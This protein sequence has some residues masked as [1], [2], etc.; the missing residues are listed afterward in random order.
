MKILFLSRWFPYPTTNGSKL[1]IYNLLRG[2]AKH[3]DVTLVSFAD[4]P[5]INPDV[6]EIRS[7]CSNVSVVPW[8]EFDPGSARARLGF[9]SFTPRSIIDTFSP[10]M[11]QTITKLLADHK[12]DLVIA[13]Q[14]SMASYRP[15]FRNV[16]A[17]FEEVEIGLSQDGTRDAYP[18]KW[19]RHAIT[20]LKLRTYLS[21]LLN[22]FQ[23]CTVASVSE[24][25]LLASNFSLH[26]VTLEVVPNCVDMSA[27][28]IIR[29]G[30]VPNQLIFSG[31][32]RYLPNY[33][34]VLWYIENVHPYVLEAV[35]DANLVIT[36]DHAN[37]PLPTV[38]NVRLAGFVDDIKSLISASSASVVPLWSGGGT[39]LKILEAMA[40]GTPVIA[41][42]KG[43]EGLRAQNEKHIL[44]ADE[45][46][47]FAECVVR[48]LRD[49]ELG[50]Q[51][52]SNARQF[53]RENYDWSITMPIFLSLAEKA[54]S[55]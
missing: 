43:A 18:L 51:V 41:T 49:K 31:S 45:P 23:A 16:P 2:L 37:L 24:K 47:K 55:G 1:R 17:I 8:R 39:R 12:Y 48:I 44:I 53:V 40:I 30:Q 20:W 28:E 5:G 34:A 22:S 11:A 19:L 21:H 29:T 50:R 7:L 26:D 54:A 27:Y 15:F 10:E 33:E 6:A 38:A 13:S 4:Q 25:D 35:P 14:L 46:R 32:F 3:H 52:S 36:G 9:L 42:T